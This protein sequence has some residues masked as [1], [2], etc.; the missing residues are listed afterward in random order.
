MNPLLI[1]LITFSWSFN[2]GLRRA[3]LA[4][5]PPYPPNYINPNY[6]TGVPPPPKPKE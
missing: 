5:P 6:S 3:L 1:Y 2:R 4:P